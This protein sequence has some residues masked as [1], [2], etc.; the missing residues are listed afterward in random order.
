MDEAWKL[1]EGTGKVTDYLK[2]C[3][4]RSEKELTEKRNQEERM[5]S[6]EKSGLGEERETGWDRMLY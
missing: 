3:R 6:T 5:I 4:N 1:F 2:Y